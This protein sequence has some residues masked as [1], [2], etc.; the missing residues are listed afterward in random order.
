M[1]SY[2]LMCLLDTAHT[3]LYSC[4]NE[5]KLPVCRTV[6]TDSIQILLY[7]VSL[8]LEVVWCATAYRIKTSL[9]LLQ[10]Y[11]VCGG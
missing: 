2:G 11:S 6:S 1:S 7:V 3:I 4:R 9:F 10:T 8:D 5:L